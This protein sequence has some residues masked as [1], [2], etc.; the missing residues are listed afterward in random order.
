MSTQPPIPPYDPR[1]QWKAYREQQRAAWRAQ[2]EAW[3]AQ[4]HVWKAGMGGYYAPRVPSVVG[5]II[6]IAI[7]VVGLMVYTGHLAM[8]TVGQWYGRW[9]PLLLIAAGLAMLAEWMLDLRRE[10]PVRRSNGFIGVLIL[11]AVIGLGLSGWNH[12]W[13]PMHMQFG[14]DGDNFFNFFGLPEHSFDQPVQTVQIPANAS[15]QIE[16]PRGDV[17][18]T[19]SDSPNI[20]VQAR[21]TAYANS[22]DEAKKIA[23]GVTPHVTVSGNAVLVRSDAND[24]S[25]VN[26]TITVPKTAHTTVNA[27]RGDITAAGLSGGLNVTAGRGDVHVNAIEGPVVVRFNGGHH[28]FSAHQVAGDVTLSGDTNDLTFSEVKGKVSVDGEIFGDVHIET[29]D[30]NVHIHTSVTQLEI[31]S[32]TGDM[33][34]NSDEL[35]VTGAKGSVRVTTKSKDVDLS[36]IYGDTYVENRNGRIAI[37]PA[38]SYNVEAKNEKGDV[39]LTLPPNVSATLNGT[40]RNGEAI[41]DFPV[42]VTGDE[43]KT[44]SGRIG[45]GT[46][47]IQLSTENGDLNI[48]RAGEEPP[49]VPATPAQP[50]VSPKAPHLKAPN[51]PPPAPVTQ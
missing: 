39:E 19:T 7:G 24:K 34:L 13:G 26:L 32:L 2:R 45:A 33:T 12:V 8:S 50:E 22:D 11:L 23:D 35:R 9:W 18:I 41:S 49:A 14:D 40:T 29:V 46:A 16:I 42:T 31:P 47:K 48:K 38:G 15:V 1:T 27:G 5:P 30:G 25:R 10:M 6:L 51:T 17:S 4:R 36:Q 28:D 37:A 44:V 43:R 3:K 21:V 20:E